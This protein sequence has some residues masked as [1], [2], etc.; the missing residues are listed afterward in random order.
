[1]ASKPMTAY[2]GEIIEFCYHY[3]LQE[4]WETR[5]TVVAGASSP[6]NYETF[7]FCKP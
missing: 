5:H 3:V 1:M 2:F 7:Y 6:C 4:K